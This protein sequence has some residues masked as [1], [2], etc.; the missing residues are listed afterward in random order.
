VKPRFE[1]GQWVLLPYR[2]TP[3][4]VQI[5]EDLGPL[6]IGGEHVFSVLVPGEDGA[7]DWMRDAAES[8]VIGLA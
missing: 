7:E 2:P 1:V 4:R 3:L 6:G 8:R 5:L